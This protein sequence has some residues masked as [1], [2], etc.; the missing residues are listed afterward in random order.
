MKKREERK[1]KNKNKNTK[2]SLILEPKPRAGLKRFVKGP[3]PIG[4]ASDHRS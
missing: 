2:K 4:L 3:L 1:N